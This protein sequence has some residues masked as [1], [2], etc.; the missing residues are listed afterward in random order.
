MGWIILFLVYILFTFFAVMNVVT[1]FFCKSAMEDEEIL[2]QAEMASKVAYEKRIR[3]LFDTIDADK[4]GSITFDELKLHMEDDEVIAILS[5][6]DIETVDAW[7]M[8][9]FL[10]A[11]EGNH[12][13][14]DEFLSGMLRLKGTVKKPDLFEVHTTVKKISAVVHQ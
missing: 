9:K 7:K 5:M 14:A 13:D 6:P 2:L 1:A 10:D 11:D 12:I 3:S 8:F 4:S